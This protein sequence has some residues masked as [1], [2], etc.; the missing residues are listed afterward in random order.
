MFRKKKKEAEPAYYM[1]PTNMRVVNYKVYV[2]SKAERI[3]FTLIAFLAG[4]A[5][6]YLFYGGLA[7]DAYGN[8]TMLT[9]ILNVVISVLVGIV[10]VKLALPTIASSLK[11]KRIAELK[12]QF[13]DMLDSLATS[14]NSG[15]NVIDSFQSVD[16]DLRMQYEESAYI[17]QELKVIMTG[18][19][20]SIDI[21]VLLSDFGRRSGVEDIESFANVFQICYRQGGNLKEVI[22]NTHSIINDKMEIER[23]IK[24]MVSTNNLQQ[25]IMIVIPVLLVAMI[26]A[27]SPE[28]A[29]NFATPTGIMAT[30]FAVVMFVVAY[31]IGKKILDIKL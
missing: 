18:I 6:G 26:K 28:F 10:A 29:A 15:K 25:K 27:V 9:Y 17:L 7:K 23:E 3:L 8:P 5:I 19:Y 12:F 13:R 4:A 11:E 24:T 16:Q 1:S 22:R 20:N 21:E 31:F 14:L 30:T 2:F